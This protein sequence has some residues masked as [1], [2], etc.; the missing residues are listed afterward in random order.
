MS[1][2]TVPVLGPIR[3]GDV[4]V[5]V[6]LVIEEDLDDVLTPVDLSTATNSTLT[7]SRPDGTTFTV[8]AARTVGAGGQ[9]TYQ[10]QAGDIDQVGNWP[11]QGFVVFT[12]GQFYTTEALLVVQRVL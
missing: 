6:E 8:G 9:I 7:F 5:V 4:G 2:Q 12:T 10:L 1:L 11:V 3:V